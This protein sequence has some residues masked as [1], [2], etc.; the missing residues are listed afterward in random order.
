LNHEIIDGFERLRRQ[1]VEAAVE[2]VMLGHRSAVET[3]ELPQRHP[4]AMRSRGSR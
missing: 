1:P 4:S 3:G 2:G